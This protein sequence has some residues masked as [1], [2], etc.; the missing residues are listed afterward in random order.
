[1]DNLTEGTEEQF[2]RSLQRRKRQRGLNRRQQRKQRPD[3][4]RFCKIPFFRVLPPA[5]N[6]F[7]RPSSNAARDAGR[8]QSSMDNLTEGTEEHF[9]RRLQRRKRQ[10]GLNRRQQ[11]KQRPKRFGF[12]KIP[13][14]EFFRCAATRFLANLLPTLLRCTS[15][16]DLSSRIEER[17]ER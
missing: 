9:N 12:A 14:L 6:P 3:K 2:N 4:I 8:E 13:F 1:M 16:N 7:S 15:E 5:G 10:R 17:S 11:R